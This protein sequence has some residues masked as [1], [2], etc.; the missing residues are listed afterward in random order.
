MTS[1]SP[2]GARPATRP[3]RPGP[4]GRGLLD[5]GARGRGERRGRRSA[6]WPPATRRPTR[7]GRDIA[8]TRALTSEPFGVNVFAARPTTVAPAVLG[9]LRRPC[10]LGQRGE[11]GVAPGEPRS[12]DDGFDA[13]VALLL[14]DPPAVVSF[15]F[16]C[17]PTALVAP[18]C[19][20]PAAEV[21]VT[22]TDVRRGAHG[23]RDRRRR[24]RRPG[25][26]GRRAPRLVRRRASAATSAC[27]RCC[28][29]PPPPSTCRSSPRAASPPVRASRRRWPPAHRRRRSA[30]RSCACDEAATCDVHR[31]ALTEPGA[32]RADAGL[33]RAHG[34]RDRQPLPA[35]STARRR[36]APTPRF[37][38]SPRRSAPTRAAAGTPSC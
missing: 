36:R 34:P 28:S 12:D 27:S 15:V 2:D 26:R 18:R 8:A 21:W 35:P 4:D 31:A 22:T 1:G 38:T 30:R 32:D 33:H 29:S 20:R 25:R 3:H 24:A 16:G 37:T 6:S 17:P 7:C 14:D 5:A 9:A 10:P 13:K 23:G 19:T 11:T